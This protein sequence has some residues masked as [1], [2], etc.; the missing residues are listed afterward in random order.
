MACIVPAKRPAGT[1]PAFPEYSHTLG[2]TGLLPGSSLQS[3]G[4]PFRVQRFLRR[5]ILTAVSPER[6]MSFAGALPQ[7]QPSMC[8]PSAPF[9]SLSGFPGSAKGTLEPS[10]PGSSLSLG[11]QTTLHTGSGLGRGL[12]G[13]AGSTPTPR[14]FSET[15]PREACR[16]QTQR[17][18]PSQTPGL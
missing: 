3:L 17:G 13:S 10:S 8:L 11:E 15:R 9:A 18:L 6:Q 14:S 4:G 1:V 5:C 12:C 7:R 2:Q 16:S